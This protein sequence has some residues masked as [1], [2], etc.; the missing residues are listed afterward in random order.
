M[1]G[2]C[3]VRIGA[4]AE[5]LSLYGT[6]TVYQSLILTA[7]STTWV[8][9]LSS[10]DDHRMKMSFVVVLLAIFSAVSGELAIAI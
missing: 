9:S 8:Y 5:Y 6:T 1:H 10:Y 7:C 3:M 4:C 2:A